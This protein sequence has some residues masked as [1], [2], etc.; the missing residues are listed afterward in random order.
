M[1]SVHVLSRRSEI[2]EVLPRCVQLAR[3]SGSV[4]VS[5]H[6]PVPLL[7]WD[8]FNSLD[9]A[10]YNSRRGTNF[11][12]AK[13]WLRDFRLLVAMEKETVLGV[14]PIVTYHVKVAGHEN[15][16]RVLTLPG[17]YQL[18][19]RQDVTVS[20]AR[21]EETV[22]RLL[23]TL[24][25][26]LEQE[27]DA[28]VLQHLPDESPSIP[29][30]RR[31]LE[32]LSQ[33]GF[34]CSAARTGRRGGVRPWTADAI[35]SCLRQAQDRDVPQAAKD[36]ARALIDDLAACPPMK[37]L[38]PRT[39]RDYEERLQAIVGA[40]AGSPEALHLADTMTSLLADGVVIY[41]MIRLPG[42]R[43]TYV[44]SLGR[45]WRTKTRNYRNRFTKNGGDLEKIA[46]ADL[47]E[48]DIEDHL[49]LHNLRW[50][51]SS[52]S[53]R[54]EASYRFHRG[55][56]RMLASDGYHTLFFARYQGTRIASCSNIDI[57]HRREAYKT[58]RD[59]AYDQWSAS[60]LVIYESILD[61]IDKGF[62]HYDLGLGW[63]AYKMAFA[64]EYSTTWN[65]F[66]TPG[67]MTLDL[68]GLYAGYECMIPS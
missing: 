25:G 43:P 68:N 40:L 23:E 9:G 27:G 64:K 45:N 1:I 42:D 58:G 51:E 60:R 56:C 48:Q 16:L 46:S 10:D 20:P 35:L 5:Q 54:G 33:R 14:L 2:D 29:A 50:G 41:P 39:R 65:F 8:L 3:E 7:W 11:L 13:S 4:L 30:L 36:G 17:D 52:A 32:D 19:S 15:L 12:G 38:F 37:L 34:G 26:L 62:S 44:S 67:G 28:V 55:L 31:A 57:L 18:M 53:L 24:A 22:R 47:T 61:S 63:Y 6:L 21:R 59:P 66:I 49:R